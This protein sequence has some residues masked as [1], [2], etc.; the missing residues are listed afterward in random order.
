MYSVKLQQQ[1]PCLACAPIAMHPTAWADTLLHQLLL[2]IA[3]A[4]DST[5]DGCSLVSCYFIIFLVSY[6]F[7]LFW[8]LVI[9]QVQ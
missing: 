4:C 8:D 3:C 9:T 2:G 5:A 1:P 6:Y 7:I